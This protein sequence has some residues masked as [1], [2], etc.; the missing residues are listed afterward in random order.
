MILQKMPR[1]EVRFSERHGG[2]GAVPS[3]CTIAQGLAGRCIRRMADIAFI[4]ALVGRACF[5]SHAGNQ[6][7]AKQVFLKVRGVKIPVISDKDCLF[8]E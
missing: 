4:N 2:S 7:F 1:A 6:A 3:V 5:S 8:A